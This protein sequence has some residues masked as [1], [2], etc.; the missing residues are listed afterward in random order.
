MN[1][2]MKK[3]L[4]TKNF[5]EE[6]FRKGNVE[7]LEAILNF[8]SKY[9]KSMNA[10]SEAISRARGEIAERLI[11]WYLYTAAQN[12]LEPQ[13]FDQLLWIKLPSSTDKA[14]SKFLAL[15]QSPEETE[16][17]SLLFKPEILNRI[18]LPSPD[19]I[20]ARNPLTQPDK[21]PIIDKTWKNAGSHTR[22]NPNKVIER[23]LQNGK[24]LKIKATHIIAIF[25]IKTSYRPDR[26]YQLLY[27]ASM[28]QALAL[29]LRKGDFIPYFSI[30]YG[31]E[32]AGHDLSSFIGPHHIA[33][34]SCNPSHQF[35]DNFANLKMLE[36]TFRIRNLEEA[37]DFFQK[38]IYNLILERLCEHGVY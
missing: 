15:L 12:G 19:L 13:I 26:R 29:L 11:V 9:A 38:H 33:Y 8:F 2:I 14:T 10:G 30:T 3:G 27:E 5:I 24:K 21:Q 16:V 31:E 37:K 23:L 22:Q 18:K 34:L 20:L 25:S 35:E 4:D 7:D 28:L 6:Q 36:G 17:G 1:K 32:K